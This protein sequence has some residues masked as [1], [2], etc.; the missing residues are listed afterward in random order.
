MPTA[1]SL[2]MNDGKTIPQIGFG[3]WQ[4]PDDEVTAA[5]LTAL[6]VGYRH[7]DTAAVY[8]NERGVGEAIARSGLERDEIF[9]TTKVWNTDHGYDQTLRAFDKSLALLGVDEVDLYLVHWPAPVTGDYLSTW[10]AVIALH[11]AGRARSIG[12]SNFHEQ[13]LTHIIDETG[14]VPVLDQIELHPWLPQAQL[15][16]KAA[17]L[18]IL[19]EAWS[20]LASGE[21]ISNPVLAAVAAEHAKSPAQ[22]MIRWHLQLGNVVLPKSVTP[23]RIRENIDVFDFALTPANMSAMAAIENGHRTGP[24]PQ[25]FM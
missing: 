11:A 9:L 14:V 25:E 23:A 3:V 19:I 10:R 18:G 21:L 1:P 2:T 7:V 20:P 15:R 4:I 22:V 13:H 17:E 8:E 5:T 12:V 6:E 24:N 16:G